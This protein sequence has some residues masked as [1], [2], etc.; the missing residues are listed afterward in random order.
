MV[1]IH[2]IL[3][4]GCSGQSDSSG[5][6]VKTSFK[7]ESITFTGTNELQYQARLYRPDAD[8]T[9]GWGVLMIGG[10]YGND[11]DWTT[12]GKY[13]I[14]GKVTQVTITGENHCDAPVIA[15]ELQRNGFTVLHYSTISIDDPLADQW[16][17]EATVR[18]LHDLTKDAIGALECLRTKGAIDPGKVIVLGHSLGATRACTIAARKGRR[19]CANTLGACV[20][21]KYIAIA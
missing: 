16:P 13:E 19:A 10:G 8:D 18:E 2:L 6:D 20:F 17:T 3:L 7:V 15:R 12:P 4:L 14:E 1:G 21:C 9:N 11:L 5:K